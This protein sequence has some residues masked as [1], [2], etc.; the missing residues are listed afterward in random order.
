MASPVH[1]PKKA[2]IADGLQLVIAADE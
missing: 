2:A 1:A